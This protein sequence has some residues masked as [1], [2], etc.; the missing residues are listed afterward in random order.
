M[1][2]ICAHV[3]VGQGLWQRLVFSSAYKGVL[4]EMKSPQGERGTERNQEEIANKS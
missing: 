3:A 4:G 2:K 1:M